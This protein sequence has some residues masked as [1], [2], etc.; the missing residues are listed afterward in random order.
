[1]ATPRRS[2]SSTASACATRRSGREGAPGR[3]RRP[4]ID[5]LLAGDLAAWKAALAAAGYPTAPDDFLLRGDLGGHGAREGIR[6]D[7]G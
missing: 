2:R 7:A 3:A 6:Y 4:P 1:M 5:E